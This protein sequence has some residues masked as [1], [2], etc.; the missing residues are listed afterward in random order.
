MAAVYPESPRPIFPVVIEPEWKTL[1]SETDGE[2]EQRRQKRL[3]ARYNVRVQYTRL[4]AAGMQALWNFYMARKGS[5]QAF[6]FYDPASMTHLGLYAG[7][8]DGETLVFDLPGKATGSQSV[9]LDGAAQS[10]GVTMLAGGGDGDADRVEFAA[11]P[12]AGALVTCD[13]T[14]RLRVR[15]RFAADRL[16]R[17]WFV[18]MLFNIG[19]ELKGLGPE[20]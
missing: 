6:Y 13:F 16:P 5:A 3:F 18:R 19:I 2:F 12:P 17:E 11:A 1:I 4:S 20:L 15:C 14:G 8:G 10:S 7:V 9:Y